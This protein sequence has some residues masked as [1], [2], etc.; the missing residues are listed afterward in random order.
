M[1]NP[2]FVK[3][4]EISKALRDLIE[5]EEKKKSQ[6]RTIEVFE[7]S[8]VMECPRRLYYASIGENTEAKISYLELKHQ[9]F[10]KKKWVDIITKSHMVQI[11]ATD[12]DVSDCDYN[13]V[14]K[15][16]IVLK[17]DDNV[18]LFQIYSLTAEDFKRV[19]EKGAIKK[20]VIEVIL[21]EWLMEKG[22]S[23]LIY[24]NRASKECLILH[25][26]TYSPIIES[27][28]EKCLQLMG[29]K[30][31]DKIPVRPYKVKSAK[32]CRQCEFGKKCWGL[33]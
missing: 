3:E 12:V 29:Y 28:K 31:R 6:V 10:I 5:E 22:E 11:V 23:V 21:N 8:H 32:E 9:E 26:K 7:T 14:G 4:D 17:Q 19:Q 25:I 16:D 27:V 1:T 30:M 15:I 33:N 24:E 20:H 13:L 18:K 2:E